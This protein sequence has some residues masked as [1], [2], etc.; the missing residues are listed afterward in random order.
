MGVFEC[1]E[2]DVEEIAS[3]KCECC[4]KLYEI[5]FCRL[6]NG[7]PY[8]SMWYGLDRCSDLLSLLN[9]CKNKNIKFMKV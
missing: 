3:Y 1:A 2:Y 5:V 4:D 9:Y 7:K 8:F 6:K